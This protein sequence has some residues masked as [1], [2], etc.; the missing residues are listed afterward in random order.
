M[1]SQSS[2][3]IFFF[4]AILA[5]VGLMNGCKTQ[6]T[7]PLPTDF[8]QI[9]AINF[10]TCSTPFD[11]Y[12][13]QDGGTVDTLPA[14]QNLQFGLAAVYSNNLTAVPAGTL[15]HVYLHHVNNRQSVLSHADITVRPGEKWGVAIYYDAATQTY[16]MDVIHDPNNGQGS[17]VNDKVYVRFLNADASYPN[18]NVYINDNQNGDV[19]VPNPGEPFRGMTDYVQLGFKT[20]TSYTFFIVDPANNNNVV[21][22]LAGV[23]FDPGSY[24][25]ISY[26]GDPCQES[27]SPAGN[28]ID[29]LRV[30]IYDDN[31]GGNDVTTPIVQTLRYNFINA[32]VPDPNVDQS[33][34]RYYTQLGIVINNDGNITFPNLTPFSVAPDQSSTPWG[35]KDGGQTYVDAAGATIYPIL[36]TATQLTQAVDVKGF[37]TDNVGAGGRGQL[38]F[39]YRAGKRADIVSD[40]P[41]SFFVMDTCAPLSVTVVDSSQAA[42]LDEVAVPIPDNAP[43]GQAIL[44]FV[45]ALSKAN[46][47]VSTVNQ[48]SFNINNSPV[49]L[50]QKKPIAAYDNKEAPIPADGSTQYKIDAILA[51]GT[52]A[53]FLNQEDYSVTFAPKP[54]KIYEIVLAGQRQNLNNYGPRILIIE[55]NPVA[56]AW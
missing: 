56:N 27:K 46:S 33:K 26:A 4:A 55:T 37:R 13:E 11:I 5:V 24:H 21:A 30:H 35:Q 1:R 40:I 42:Y 34:I 23:S 50:F 28:P 10:A 45:N 54:G 18:L 16:P 53:P 44:V 25:T 52:K 47:A 3:R 38:L 7:D 41:T 12:I 17:G 43:A 6:V 32:L 19:L 48:A 31:Y 8:A 9:R 14:I 36:F 29:S 2:Q 22:R 15:Y 20:D 49:T 39:D 51:K